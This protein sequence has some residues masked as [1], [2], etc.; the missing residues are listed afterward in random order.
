MNS[1]SK[2]VLIIV[3]LIAI[4]FQ[5][6]AQKRIA[7]IGDS[8]TEGYGISDSSQSYP[9][10]L[11]KLLGT[12]FKIG[13]FGHSGST[14]L[15]NGHNP[16]HKTKA[17]KEA[18]LFKPN[19]IVIA[20]G[21]NDT[22]PRN[23]PNFKNEFLG[24]YSQ[25][26]ND[27]KKVNPKVEVFICTMTPIFSGHR[28]FLSGTREWFD[29]I[30]SLIPEIAK[31]HGATVIDNHSMLAPRIDLFAD[32]LHPNS[33][34]AE[35]IAH[36][37]AI[38]LKPIVQPLSV[39]ETFGNDMVLQRGVTNKLMG[40]S[41]SNE[42]VSVVFKNKTYSTTAARNGNWEIDIPTQ[43]AGG[44][45]RLDISSKDSKITL[46]NVLFGDVYLSSGQSNMAFKFRDALDSDLL[47]DQVDSFDK[48]RVFKNKNLAETSN[49]Q[50]DESTL[51]KV[52]ELQYFSGKWQKTSRETIAEFSAIAYMTA[53]ELYKSQHVPIGII[54]ISV[55]GSNTE[56]WISRYVLE[57]DNL[58][59]TYIHNW[60][61]S[62]FIQDF[63]RERGTK[64]IELAKVKHQR[65]PYDPAYNFEAGISKWTNTK[66]KGV[67][68]YQG[69]SNAHNIEHHEYLFKKMIISWRQ[70]FKNENLP[71]Y[72]V[73]LSG[74]NRPSWGDFRDSQRK[75]SNTIKNTFMAVSSD[76]GHP[77]DVH[78]K[79]KFV[80]GKR[81]ANLI[82]QHM[83]HEDL[84]ADS[85]QPVSYKK[86][87]GE[88]RV[89]FS[90]CKELKIKDSHSIKDL[91][92]VTTNGQILK[93]IEARIDKNLLIIPTQQEIRSVQYGYTPFTNGNL[94]SDTDVPVSTFNLKIN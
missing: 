38:Y 52:N 43:A 17:Y 14:L 3:S 45:Y 89:E 61:S 82:R 5:S 9:A 53:V 21:L 27:F 68:W 60:K 63:C 71:F 22:D 41:S 80:I 19:A 87:N 44:P 39:D 81:L 29:Q 36:N 77:T 76:V 49:V 11:Q 15:R 57:H 47:L 84:M 92:V 42:K 8:V 85:P 62:D 65:H 59:A 18:L 93:N 70:A 78:P 1:L 58:L 72:F 31:V 55:G 40:K 24:D 90:H 79:D 34:G 28:R 74:I 54:D 94:I 66:L 26:I 10:Q 64:N 51:N 50:W 16:Y 75:L 91:Q 23:W 37:V 83:Y 32:Y 13:N 20:L 25:L 67:L 88:I 35:L 56:S 30:Q 4:A 2:I 73:Q 86:I 7:C 69:E 12:E 33:R 6:F 48:I 46:T